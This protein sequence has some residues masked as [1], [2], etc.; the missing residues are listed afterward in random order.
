MS[1]NQAEG[2]CKQVV[3]AVR[4]LW[5][6]LTNDDIAVVRGRCEMLAGRL[7][8]SYGVSR[9]PARLH[10]DQFCE[11]FRLNVTPEGHGLKADPRK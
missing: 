7:Q 11:W 6:I 9:D 1:W 8:E 5:G 10:A 4:K 2:K 3:G